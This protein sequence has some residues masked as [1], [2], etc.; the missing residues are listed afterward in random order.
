[1]LFSGGLIPF[2]LVVQKVGLGDSLWA[3]IIPGLITTSNLMIMRTSFAA[4]PPDLEESAKI[5]G[6]GDWRVLF[7]I[8]LPL[9]RVY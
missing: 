8:V 3:L 4:V 9:S 1:M 2:Y 5:D 6:A 7:Q